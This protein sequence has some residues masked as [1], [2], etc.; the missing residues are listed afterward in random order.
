M[1]LKLAW[2]NIWRNKRRTFITLGSVFFAV[3]LSTLMMSIKEG[4]YARMIS[5]MVG[6]YTGYVQVHAPGYW[7][8]RSLDDSMVIT[9]SLLQT[10][11]Q[12]NGVT[13]YVPRIENF[14]LAASEDVTKGSMVV[15]MDIELEKQYSAIHERISEG[16][17]FEKGDKSVLVGAGLAEYLKLGVGDTIVLLG[18]GYHGVSAAGKY[19]IKGIVKF[20]SPDLSKQLVILP[21]PEAQ[22]FYGAENKVTN[23]VVLVDDPDESKKIQKT[24]KASLSDSYDVMH[25]EEM[26]PDIKKLIETDRVEGYV[27]MFILYMVIAFGIFGTMLM[28]MAERMHEFGV[29]IAVGMKRVNLAVM[30]WIETVMISLLGA[31]LGMF[32][33]LPVCAYFYYWP[34]EFSKG[35]EMA[36][37][38]EEYGMEAVL[39]ASIEPSVFLQQAA[40]VALVATVIAVYPFLRI[41]RL[42]AINA[43]SS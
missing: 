16:S 11:T 38:Y 19:P 5:S 29:L 3:I 31:F 28:M 20:G 35:D 2:R 12:T 40:V 39:Q 14:A 21:L 27:F 10:V 13:G 15:G 43:M 17:Y 36:K 41:L 34:I 24:L 32:G 23:M 6:T 26:S 18:A 25:W 42:K 9:D 33:A 8:D 4:I 1:Q 37:M 22:W 30:V 7:E